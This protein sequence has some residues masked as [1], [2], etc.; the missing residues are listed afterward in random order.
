LRGLLQP[1]FAV[2]VFAE[3]GV[4]IARGEQAAADVVVGAV[5]QD[6]FGFAAQQ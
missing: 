2:V 6:G 4:G 3:C 5:Q 1:F